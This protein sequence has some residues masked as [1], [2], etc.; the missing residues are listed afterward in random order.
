LHTRSAGTPHRAGPAFLIWGSLEAALLYGTLAAYAAVVFWQYPPWC[1]DDAYIVFRYAKHLAEHGRLVWNLEGPPVEGYTGVALP[2]LV[3]AGMRAGIAPERLTHALGMASYFGL[4]W[5]LADNQRRLGV[6]PVARAYVTAATMV[7]PPFFAHATSGLETLEF[8]AV[9]CVCFGQLLACDADP[10]PALHARLWIAL[11]VLSLLRPEGPL[12]AFAFGAAVLARAWPARGRLQQAAVVAGCY[13]VPYGAYFAWRGSYYGRLFPNTYYAKAAETGFDLGFL[14]SLAT[15]VCKEFAP[16]VLAGVVL[17]VCFRRT[18][19]PRLPTAAA[20][21]AMAVLAATYSRS[22]LIQGFCYR[23]EVP[24]LV[25]LVPFL[26]ALLGGTH[27]REFPARFGRARGGLLAALVALCLAACPIEFMK[28]EPDLAAQQGRYVDIMADTEAPAGRWLRDHLPPSERV[29]LWLDAGIVP[30]LADDHQ[31]IDFGRLNDAFLARP[32]VTSREVADY[33]FALRP[34]ALVQAEN[35]ARTVGPQ[36]DG[37]ILTADP[38]F[39]EYERV[40]RFCSPLH[41][42]VVCLG[43]FLRR[44]VATR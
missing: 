9:L 27:L 6:P 18:R 28:A 36:F 41:R 19:L 37:A 17:G 5:A 13:L 24:F 3:A 26:G 12:F 33:F 1:V 8:A 38:R 20:F 29:A 34:G 35:T 43:L 16:L 30:L 21:G 22:F 42:D 4:A 11:L 32:G 7:F 2:V 25:L 15:L 23:F 14:E 44:G 39:A 10:R 31:A 40:M